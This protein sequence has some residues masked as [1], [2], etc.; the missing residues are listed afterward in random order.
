M[1][2]HE[3]LFNQAFKLINGIDE[4][5]DINYYAEIKA[6]DEY[7]LKNNFQFIAKNENDYYTAVNLLS[8]AVSFEPKCIYIYRLRSIAYKQL[9]KLDKS[10]EDQTKAIEINP[11]CKY[12]Y[13]NR[14]IIKV[15]QKD[16]QGALED[17]TK[18]IELG[19]ENSD[20]YFYR[21]T[22]QEEL[23]NYEI[24]IEDY[25]KRLNLMPKITM[26]SNIVLC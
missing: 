11:Q 16:F 15:K 24:A 4:E 17:F 2:N 10:I 18:A 13:G 9:G 12:A 22:I 3:I 1:K 21:G 25:S 19:F 20:I 26:L 5:I 6:D 7:T 14:G 23:N 8:E